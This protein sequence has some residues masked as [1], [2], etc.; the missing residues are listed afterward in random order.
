VVAGDGDDSLAMGGGDDFVDGGDTL[1]G[2]N[3]IDTASFASPSPVSVDLLAG[4][5]TG[6]GSDSLSIFEAVG[7][8]SFD[9]VLTGSGCDEYFVPMAGDDTVTGGTGFDM[10]LFPYA[11]QV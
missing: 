7:G 3:G 5:A 6:T 1:V 4:T 9:D 10:V 11:E 2:G 8:L